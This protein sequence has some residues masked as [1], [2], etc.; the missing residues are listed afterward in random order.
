MKK[1]VIFE[2]TS[3]D[4]DLVTIK[5][6][7]PL[8]GEY[9]KLASFST[10]DAMNLLKEV[11]DYPFEFVDIIEPTTITNISEDNRHGRWIFKISD[12]EVPV[13]EIV[14]TSSK[15]KSKKSK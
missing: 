13:I 6:S 2:G 3:F 11:V 7:L 8:A 12:L 5:A 10:E 14:D 15:K 9:D 4:G 1:T